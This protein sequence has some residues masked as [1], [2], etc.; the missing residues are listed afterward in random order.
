VSKSAQQPQ[1][2]PKKS[3]PNEDKTVKIQGKDHLICDAPKTCVVIHHSYLNRLQNKKSQT[4]ELHQL[5]GKKKYTRTPLSK[6]PVASA[7]LLVPG[8]SLA[9]A[10]LVIPLVVAT[11]LADLHLID[12]Q[13]DFRNF[14]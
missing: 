8:L 6:R 4:D 13:I 5:V 9:G 3:I 2:K 11:F 7:L 1:Q 14:L 10:E 12:D